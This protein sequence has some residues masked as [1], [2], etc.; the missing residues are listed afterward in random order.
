MGRLRTGA[1]SPV[2]YISS[3]YPQTYPKN[4]KAAYNCDSVAT[5]PN[6][7][8]TGALSKANRMC[9][10]P[11]YLVACYGN[12]LDYTHQTSSVNTFHTVSGLHL[13]LLC[14]F[15]SDTVSVLVPDERI[16][17]PT[18]RLQGDCTTAVLIRLAA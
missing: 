13:F 3:A 2:F 17:L 18:F 15:K 8:P 7:I 10:R 11:I 1:P 14:I 6:A 4:K 12:S 16:E 9:K 5:L